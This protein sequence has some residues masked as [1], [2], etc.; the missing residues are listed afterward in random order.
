MVLP[1]LYADMDATWDR[2]Y[3]F[4]PYRSQGSLRDRIHEVRRRSV[5]E[6]CVGVA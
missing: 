5:V 2:L 1:T 3:V 6:S 4:Q